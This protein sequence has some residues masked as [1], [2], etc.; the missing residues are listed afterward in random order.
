MS[1]DDN[2]PTQGTYLQ[3]AHANNQN[4]LPI[5]LNR[6]LEASAAGPNPND[7]DENGS[8]RLRPSCFLGVV[9]FTIGMRPRIFTISLVVCGDTLVQQIMSR[10][11]LV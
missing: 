2:P 10:L 1:T 5:E 7:M 3:S 8:R 11:M 4:R 9:S 6:E